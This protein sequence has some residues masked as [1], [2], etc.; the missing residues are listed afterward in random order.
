MISYESLILR[1]YTHSMKITTDYNEIREWV[2]QYGGKPQIIHDP[3]AKGSE[4]GLRFDF[5]G[6]ADNF[7]LPDAKVRDVSWDE[8]FKTFDE[9]K[10]A[11]LYNEDTDPNVVERLA[12]GYHFIRRDALNRSEADENAAIDAFMKQFSYDSS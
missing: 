8:F 12:E 3:T 9:L 1:A 4:T 10:M 2:E 5:P 7:F 6:E 11:F